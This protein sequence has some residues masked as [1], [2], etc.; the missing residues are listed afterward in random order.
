MRKQSQELETME[1][2]QRCQ[3]F[4]DGEAELCGS[5]GAPTRFMSFKK[6]A[7][8]EVEQ[9]RRHKASSSAAS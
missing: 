5:C 9:W 4:L 6:R 8:W 3:S 7:E 1:T 2:C